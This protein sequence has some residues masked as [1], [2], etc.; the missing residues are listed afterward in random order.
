MSAPDPKANTTTEAY[1][2]YKAGY[3]EESGLK[4]KLYKPDW[5]FDG[6]LAYWTGLTDTYPVKDV[7]KNLFSGDFSQFDNTGGTGTLYAYFKL[8]DDGEYTLTLIAKN[9]VTGT[10]GTYFGFT[11]TG[12]DG[13]NPRNWVFYQNVT[14]TQGETRSITNVYGGVNQHY[15]SLYLASSDTLQWFMDNFEIQLEKG[16]TATAYEP[17]TGKP[18][19]LND[20]EA[21]VAYLAGV[22]DTYPEEIKDPYDVRIVGYLRHLASKRWPEP[23]YPVNNE[24]FYLSTMEPTHTS[25]PE[26]SSDIELDTAEGKIISVEAYG[27]TTQNG[28]PTPDEPV[29]IN[30]V[31][32]VQSVLVHGKNLCSECKVTLNKSLIW[33]KLPVLSSNAITLSCTLNAA[34]TGNSYDLAIDGV[35]TTLG[36]W[37]QP[38]NTRLSRQITFTDGQLA[39]INASSDAWIRIY[40]SGAGFEMPNDYMIEYGPTA[41]TYEPYQGATYA[42]D[43]GDTEL[44]KIGTY[45]DKI[46]NNDPNEDWYDPNLEDNAWYVHKEMQSMTL[47]GTENWKGPWSDPNSPDYLSVYL[48]R[49]DFTNNYVQSLATNT[50]CNY[51]TCTGASIWTKNYNTYAFNDNTTYALQFKISKTIVDSVENW[52]TW[53]S[54]HNT[55]FYYPLATPTD[56]KITDATLISELEALAGA[57]TYD[58]KTFINVAA[59]DPNLPALL[60]VEAY[61]Y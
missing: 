58:G 6:W 1:L 2:A 9:N 30:V 19:M 22:T 26:P 41:T 36:S 44:C 18:E 7:G 28:T 24:E 33:F 27:D 43:L 37:S 61:K 57:Y 39:K 45:Q 20:E 29:N 38:A 35:A 55:I 48:N 52:K 34:L 25:N 56:T 4:P 12:G 5:H 11:T 31:T 14:M 51:F 17:Y 3:L 50:K 10:S 49:T 16:S 53:L 54:S 8:P 21:L 32:G 13:T 60:K 40:K 15:V 47:N 42:I 23:D 46:F 59:N